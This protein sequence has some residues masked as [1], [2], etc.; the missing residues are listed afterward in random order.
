VDS[1]LSGFRIPGHI[2]SETVLLGLTSRV[3]LDSRIYSENARE[4]GATWANQP[5]RIPGNE[6]SKPS[7]S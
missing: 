4:E 6:L 7:P 1:T 2:D 3:F 5:N